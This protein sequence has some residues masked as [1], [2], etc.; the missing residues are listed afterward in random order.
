MSN[1][2]LTGVTDREIEEA[3][4]RIDAAFPET[5]D[6]PIEA[7]M[8]VGMQLGARAMADELLGMGGTDSYARHRELYVLAGR[9]AFLS[10]ALKAGVCRRVASSVAVIIKGVTI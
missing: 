1:G 6:D 4:G 10:T 5:R 3:I 2:R 9:T 8:N 7:A